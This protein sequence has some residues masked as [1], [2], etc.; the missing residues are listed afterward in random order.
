MAGLSRPNRS[1]DKP[2]PRPAGRARLLGTTAIVGVIAALSASSAHANDW[3]GTVSSD[4]FTAGNWS[5]GVPT[6]A[7]PN[8]SIANNGVPSSPVVRS[9]G[10]FGVILSIGNSFGAGSLYVLNGGTLHT[11]EVIVADYGAGAAVVSG[12]GSTWTA[13]SL[14]IGLVGT[15]T[16][17]VTNGGAVSAQSLLVGYF[18][19]ARSSSA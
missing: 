16:V 13:G 18:D 5:G 2:Y 7:D 10:A 19:T 15:G 6:T 1:S 12:T 11:Q 17:I 9:Q 8:V 14:S 3:T 4:G